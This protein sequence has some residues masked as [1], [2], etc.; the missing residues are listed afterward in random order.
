MTSH[1][2]L[3]ISYDTLP[4]E[5]WARVCLSLVDYDCGTGE[6]ARALSL[7]CRSFHAFIRLER[8]K[9][10][11][12]R[13][14]RR[15]VQF[16]RVLLDSPEDSLVRQPEN[17]FILFSED[18]FGE[19]EHSEDW[20]DEID[21]EKRIASESEDEDWEMTSITS[22]ERQEVQ[23]DRT[24]LSEQ[25]SSEKAS[26]IPEVVRVPGTFAEL[27]FQESHR[28]FVDLVEQLIQICGPSLKSLHWHTATSNTLGIGISIP[29]YRPLPKLEVLVTSRSSVSTVY[30]SYW[31]RC[32]NELVDHLLWA[33]RYKPLNVATDGDAGPC[34]EINLPVLRILHIGLPVASRPSE[35]NLPYMDIPDEPVQLTETW[36]NRFRDIVMKGCPSLQLFG[37]SSLD[38]LQNEVEW[39]S[40][41]DLDHPRLA[42]MYRKLMYPVPESPLE[43]DNED[44]I[45]VSPTPHEMFDLWR[46]CLN[47]EEQAKFDILPEIIHPELF[48]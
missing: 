11:A 47:G 39:C 44:G 21:E 20:I 48:P 17:L 43:K 33:E 16:T 6:N 18:W 38:K 10:I 26:F 36:F 25:P 28:F 22:E 37:L 7:T 42:S 27:P 29:A 32:Q 2:G 1:F 13:D 12:L 15:I 3:R 19:F 14:F 40:P 31:E 5:M 8:W 30:E 45:L 35:E 23:E 34:M 46:R 4:P 9:T 24:W 41:Q